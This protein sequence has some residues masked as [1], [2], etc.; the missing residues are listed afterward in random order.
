[1]H[2]LL[3]MHALFAHAACRAEFAPAWQELTAVQKGMWG[4]CL[5]GYIG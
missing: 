3:L 2:V 1:M 5:L 4:L